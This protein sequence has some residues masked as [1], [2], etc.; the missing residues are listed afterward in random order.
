[1][2]S[3]GRWSRASS[4]VGVAPHAQ[5]QLATGALRSGCRIDWR[6]TRIAAD[7]NPSVEV[8]QP[9]QLG[10]CQLL[11]ACSRT[12]NPACPWI[13]RLPSGPAKNVLH[14]N[15]RSSTDCSRIV[16]H[17]SF[18]F[19]TGGSRIVCHPGFDFPTGGS[20]IVCHP[21]FYFRTGGSRVACHPSAYFPTCGWRSVRLPIGDG[22]VV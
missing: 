10:L 11:N 4:K 9:C 8:P 19:P 5:R 2:H 21:S 15:D 20:R 16:C 6:L 1:M 22:S 14:P 17:L 18:D 3:P 12:G 13:D 7:A